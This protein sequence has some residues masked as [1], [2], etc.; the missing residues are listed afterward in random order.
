MATIATSAGTLTQVQPLTLP[1]GAGVEYANGDVLHPLPDAPLDWATISYATRNL[2]YRDSLLATKLNETIA[3][4]NNRE[5]PINMP[6]V[7]TVLGPGQD[8]VVAN[9]RIPAGFEAR[10]LNLAVASL[11][12][13]QGCLAE[14]LWN[15]TYGSNDGQS[16]ASTFGEVGAGTSFYGT[17]E[18]VLRIANGGTQV[19]TASASALFSLRP[20][21]DQDGAVFG[22][23]VQ[24]E[25]GDTGEK[26]DAGDRGDAGPPGPP[27]AA[28]LTFRGTWS[29]VVSYALNDAVTY[30][31][32]RLVR[33]PGAKF[34]RGTA[35]A[36][37]GAER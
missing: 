6:A 15:A 8:I 10:V 36:K 32:R 16:I 28:G 7:S 12:T 26:G 9:L 11:P 25:K 17:G 19:I 1:D 22:P 3:V 35:N 23:G 4:V 2:A 31:W 20:V 30:D 13:T 14:V 33:L 5:T 27:G 18:L 24:G 37:P 34:E 29:A 21:A